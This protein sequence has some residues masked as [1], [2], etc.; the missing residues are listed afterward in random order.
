VLLCTT[1]I[2]SGLDIPNVNTIIIDRADTFGLA[3][4][5]QLR[6][7]VGRGIN[8]A[9][10]YLFFKPPLSD[11]ARKRLQTIREASELGAGFRVAMRDMEIRGAGEIL[12]A[13]QHGHIAAIGFDLY[14]RL[15][16]QAVQAL[17]EASGDALEAVRRAQHAT[18]TQTL[19]LGYGPSLDLP[20]SA[21]LP[22]DFIPEGA[23]RLRLYRRL[24]RVE[25][26]EELDA[27]MREMRDRFG[28][29]PKPVEQL[30]YL[31]RVRVLAAQAGV[32]SI[33]ANAGEIALALPLPLTAQGAR[34]IASRHP[35]AR[36][37]GSRVWLQLGDAWQPALVGLLRTL[38]ET[39]P[40][41]LSVV[42]AP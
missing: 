2:E 38:C 12:G 15:L 37:R 35:A 39:R 27:F 6:G 4:L 31:L 30:L 3:Q 8:R 18:A 42:G 14:M 29:L 33:R 28:E 16:R 40:E 19:A 24:A 36:A 9:Y 20:L 23:L 41:P 22:D 7:R 25:D 26:E 5:Y 13:E 17:Q 34:Q 10:A 11:V 21:H 32:E 1:I